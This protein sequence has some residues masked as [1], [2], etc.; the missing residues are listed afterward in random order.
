M[1]IVAALTTEIWKNYFSCVS[2]SDCLFQLT[3][4]SATNNNDNNNMPQTQYHQVNGGPICTL[5]GSVV[6]LCNFL[7][8]ISA[9]TL[10]SMRVKHDSEV[11]VQTTKNLR[12]KLSIHTNIQGTVHKSVIHRKLGQLFEGRLC[13]CWESLYMD[14][15]A[16][17]PVIALLLLQ[18]CTG[19]CLYWWQLTSFLICFLS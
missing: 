15:T 16:R 19:L 11:G 5:P 8:E 2:Y 6:G 10:R 3:A 18:L 12:Y 4:T 13:T 1:N 17:S 14:T 9:I 7:P